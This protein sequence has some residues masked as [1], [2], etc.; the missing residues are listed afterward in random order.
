[1]RIHL[2]TFPTLTAVSFLAPSCHSSVTSERG[3]PAIQDQSM[4][5]VPLLYFLYNYRHWLSTAT[6]VP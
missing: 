1:M 2:G 3:P 6:C 5:S 4:S